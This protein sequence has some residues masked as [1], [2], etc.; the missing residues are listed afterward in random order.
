M[1]PPYAGPVARLVATGALVALAVAAS[2]TAL[3]QLVLPGPWVRTGVL[4]I[5]LVTVTTTTTRGL[6]EARAR[7]RGVA[8]DAGSGSALPTLAGALVATWFVLSRY[9]APTSAA[10]LI[11]GPE[12]VSRVVARLGEA[13]EIIRSEVAPVPGTLPMALLTVGGTLAVL[14]LADALAGGLHWHAGVGLPL[15]ALWA[16][17]LVLVGSVP[18]LVFVVVVAALLL[19]LTVSPRG[20]P[21]TRQ[22]EQPPRS[23]RR[24]EG[25]RA[26]VTTAVAVVVAAG[27]GLVATASESLPGYAGAWYQTFTTSGDAIQ[28]A[29][30]LDVLGSLTE[31]SSEVV[32]TYTGPTEGVGPWRTYTTSAFDGRRWQR[33]DERSGEPFGPDDL[34]WPEDVDRDALADARAVAVTVGSLRD[35]QLPVPGEPRRVTVGGTWGYDAVRDEVVGD[36]TDEGE[37]FDVAVRPRDLDPE[38][39]RAAGPGTAVD[40]YLQ[41][42]ETDRAADVAALA[43]EVAGDGPTAY[44]QA[45]ALQRWLRDPSSFTYSTELP[46]GGTGDPVWDFLQH[47]TGYCVQFATTMTMMARTLDIPARLAVGFLPGEVVSESDSGEQATWQVTGQD[48]HAW[49][50]LYFDGV[51]WVR[52]EPTPAVQTGAPP[53][54]TTPRDGP[55][56]G[57][58]DQAP[59]VPEQV[60]PQERL[61]QDEVVSQPPVAVPAGGGGGPEGP[62]PWVWVVGGIVVVAAGVAGGFLLRRRREDRPVDAERAWEQV[63]AALAKNGVSLP[64]PTTPRQAPEAIVTA[65]TR[66]H[67]QRPS[68]EV[69]DGLQRIADAVERSRYAAP[70][71]EAQDDDLA[72]LAETVAS[73]LAQGRRARRTASSGR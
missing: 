35:D 15:L 55:A 58:Q 41:V 7:R 65:V 38:R 31:R 44:D 24:A 43:E 9:G 72:E 11:V 2:M 71:E 53:T 54:H 13:G 50:E 4:G 34:L 18:R 16:P 27:A 33:G 37:T 6:L 56:A 22:R 3:T 12:H 47:R 59:E 62:E 48:S 67:G 26:V 69:R 28:L 36:R 39:L 63:L 66:A 42:P 60:P 61:G 70:V 25:L 14:L 40:A 46:R 32:L 10:D 1:I 30:D 51:G 21:R 23:V 5:V 73:G 49:P 19:L 57:Q 17:P 52:F 64:P 29:E 68:P 45:V 20:G 8:G